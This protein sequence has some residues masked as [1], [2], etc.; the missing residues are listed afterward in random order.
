MY[1]LIYKIPGKLRWLSL[2]IA[3]FIGILVVASFI[4]PPPAT[5]ASNPTPSPAHDLMNSYDSSNVVTNGMSMAIDRLSEILASSD[6][7]VNSSRRILATSV[8]ISGR[9]IARGV[10]TGAVHTG[11]SIQEAG[12]FTAYISARALSTDLALLIYIP[13]TIFGVAA[14]TAV[15]SAIVTPARDVK[16]PTIDPAS[17]ATL[18]AHLPLPIVTAPTADPTPATPAPV[19]APAQTASQAAVL[20]DS[21]TVWPLHG[22]ITTM[23]GVP[24]LPYQA[25]HTGIDISDGWHAGNTPVK[26]FKSGYV[27]EVI[28][29]YFGLGNHVVVDHGNGMTSVY[30]HL[31]STAVQVGELVNTQTIVGLEGS[32]GV[33]TGTH[34]HFEVRING[35]PTDPHHFI[36]GQP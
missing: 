26:S 5:Y 27:L 1:E 6:Q 19:T 16:V 8:F 7:I 14:N 28:H 32:T 10:D 30:G 35:V 11:H 34:L 25:I 15:V 29:S 24:E 12:I 4:L 17:P 33:S 13:R 9:F 36:N 2:G 18:A 22:T 3:I 21:E 31:Y 20:A 23:F